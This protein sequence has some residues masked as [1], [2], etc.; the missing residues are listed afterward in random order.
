MTVYKKEADVDYHIVLTDDTGHTMVAEIPS[1]A[2]ILAQNPSGPGR[3]LVSSPFT[4]GIM[5]SRAKFDSRFTA[6]SF[7][8]T[9]NVPVRVTGVGFFDFIHGQTGVAPN[10]IELH[11]ILSI[12]FTANTSTTLMSSA[13]PSQY[14]QSV[15]ITATVSNGG[16]STPTGNLNFFDGGT[17][18]GSRTLD[19]NGQATFES[20]TLSTGSHSITASYEG[21]TTSS[22][23]TSAALVQ[24]I[25][26]ASSTTTVTCTSS[27]IYTG[28]AIEPCSA[29]VTGAGGLNQTVP[30]TYSR[31]QHLHDHE[32]CIHNDGQ[33]SN[34]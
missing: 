17:L 3:V 4:Q 33:L 29:I 21:D 28:G 5:D 32:G 10:G 25:N 31:Q 2:C 20:S 1:P 15:S 22:P 23:S 18:V 14:G 8:Q 6:T 24:V 12:D 16:V 7:F 19:Q 30:V 11:P 27:E 9:A 13:N 26:K 34:E